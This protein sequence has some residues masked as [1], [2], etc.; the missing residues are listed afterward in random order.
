[1]LQRS[2]SVLAV[3]VFILLVY[4]YSLLSRRLEGTILTIPL[5][6]TVAGVVLVLLVPGLVV[7]RETES[8]VWLILAEITYAIVLFNGATRVN[9]RILGGRMQL[10]GRL[11]VFGLPLTI[12]LGMLVAALVLPDLALWEAGI[13]ACIL[14][15]TDTGLAEGIVRSPRVPACIREA[16]NAES[17][18]SDGL[19]IPFLMLFVSLI[20]VDAAGPGGVFLRIAVQQIGFGIPVGAAIGFVG[21][22]LLG[23]ARRRGWA[24]APFQQIA[25][26]ALAP[27]C[28]IL[29]EAIGTSPFIAAFAAG[30]AVQAGFRDASEGLV[31]FSENEGRLLHMFVF[32]LFGTAA[33]PALGEFHL[34]P[35]LYA[36]LSLTLVRMLPVAISMIGTR[37]S[38]ASLLFVGW[39]GPR[40]LASIVLSLVVVQ[41][42]VQTAGASV[43]RLGLMATVLLSIFAH[44]LSASPGIRLYAQQIAR[45]G[46]DA[47]EYE[48]VPEMPA[49]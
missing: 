10:P 48:A 2:I 35:V 11:L 19:V 7:R 16:L 40:G 25:M 32:F 3:I 29:A 24:S 38:A 23:L 14:A 26:I 12:L 20:K 47:P 1:L 5:V 8:E 6:F 45:L 37:L 27:L 4:V 43:V 9:L 15:A 22:W 13:L 42:E 46:T 28:L 34:A 36:I 33:G 30:I 44:G 18:L 49:I 39:F 41:L 21:G 17:G 31:E